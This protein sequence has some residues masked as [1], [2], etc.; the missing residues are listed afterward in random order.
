M[1]PKCPVI[2]EE[3]TVYSEPQ[4]EEVFSGRRQNIPL[5]GNHGC[6]DVNWWEGVNW[7]CTSVP[8]QC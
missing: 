3:E 4:V 8:S 6:A 5:G 7:L 1:W 2:G